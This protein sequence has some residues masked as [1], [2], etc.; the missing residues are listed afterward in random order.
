MKSKQNTLYS[1]LVFL[2]RAA[3]MLGYL[4]NT[5]KLAALP[6][7]QA[8]PPCDNCKTMMLRNLSATE[9][10]ILLYKAMVD[11][12]PLQEPPWYNYL[13]QYD[14]GIITI[15]YQGDRQYELLQ[16]QQ[17]PNPTTPANA[18]LYPYDQ[19]RENIRK[20]GKPALGLSP[21]NK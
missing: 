21:P 6:C 19:R 20:L 11:S 14:L 18:Y 10:E 7:E 3:H 17:P 12:A 16:Y 5:R 9:L 2:V 4:W 8:L 13:S 15:Y 1:F